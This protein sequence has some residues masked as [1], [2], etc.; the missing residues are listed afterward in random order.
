MSLTH[1][2]LV[3]NP[4]LRDAP[5][6]LGCGVAFLV[7]Y[8]V[9]LITDA[10]PPTKAHRHFNIGREDPELRSSC[11]ILSRYSTV[12]KSL[13][14]YNKNVYKLNEAKG[15]WSTVVYTMTLDT[16]CFSNGL[17]F[18]TQSTSILC[19][20]YL[21]LPVPLPKDETVK[22]KTFYKCI[23]CPLTKDLPWLVVTDSQSMLEDE[24]S[25]IVKGALK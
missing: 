15:T 16:N 21:S 5:F 3:K 18:W 20:R 7:M 9:V 19:F 24:E 14:K 4:F 13:R 12:P 6:C 10:I 8:V 2:F 23:L 11:R 17:G 25:K 1:C 22:Q